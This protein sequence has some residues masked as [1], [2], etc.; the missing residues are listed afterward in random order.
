MK[1]TYFVSDVH[2]PAKRDDAENRRLQI[3]L[4][5]LDEIKASA[6]CLFIVG[7]LFDFWFEYN[8]VIPKA[9]FIVLHHLAKLQEQGIDLHYLA[10]NH[11]FWLGSFLTKE[12]GIATYQNTWTGAID[13]KKFFLFHGDGLAKRDIG[14]R[15]IKR[16][17]RN[18]LTIRLY[19]LLHP[20]FGIPFAHMVSG[21]SRKYSDKINLK[22]ADDY[23]AF[24]RKQFEQ[25]YD[26]VLMGHRH[27]PLRHE[28]SGK[29]YIN[30]GDWLDKFTYARFDGTNLDL[31]SYRI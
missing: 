20:D 23:L 5:F 6:K 26:F 29:V 7:D 22:D 12:L 31:K 10:G 2:I 19:R 3:F 28:E 15:F 30:L 14:Y 9:H 17:F 4:R 21:T 18:R 1:Y 24:A 8:Y 25:G 27:V 11:D 16:I 13:G